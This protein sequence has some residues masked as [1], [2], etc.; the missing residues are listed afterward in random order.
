MYAVCQVPGRQ[1]RVGPGE[2]V[3]VDFIGSAKEGDPIV[4]DK[5]L[6]VSDGQKTTVGA[7]F[8]TA[9]VKGTVLVHGRDDKIVVYKKKKR[10]DYHKMH[11]HKQRFTTV[12]IDSIEM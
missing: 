11:G 9:K 5:V 8:V 6:L 3:R 12:R 4:F 7:P 2:T 1:L 10:T